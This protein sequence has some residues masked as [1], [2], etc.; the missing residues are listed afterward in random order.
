MMIKE[1]YY[2]CEKCITSYPEARYI[3]PDVVLF[4]DV[5]EWFTEK[6]FESS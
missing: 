1:D 4:R 5:G 3:N 2:V 6:G